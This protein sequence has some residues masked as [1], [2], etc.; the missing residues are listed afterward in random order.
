MGEETKSERRS[1]NAEFKIPGELA[2]RILT[3]GFSLFVYQAAPFDDSF[4]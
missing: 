2:S 4:R 3:S 1:E